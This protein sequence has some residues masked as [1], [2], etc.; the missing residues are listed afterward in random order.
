VEKG[1]KNGIRRGD[2]MAGK[3]ALAVRGPFLDRGWVMQAEVNSE[4]LKEGG[5]RGVVGAGGRGVRGGVGV[6]GK[7]VIAW[8]GL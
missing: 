4:E 2:G 6:R 5:P 3:E 8:P 1:V 7:K